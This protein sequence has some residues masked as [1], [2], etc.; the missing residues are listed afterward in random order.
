MTIGTPVALTNIQSSTDATSYASASV[1]PTGNG[2]VLVAFVQSERTTSDAE[3]PSSIVAWGLTW[4]NTPTAGTLSNAWTTGGATNRRM[5]GWW[6][7]C[8]NVPAAG[9][10]TANFTNTH[11]G[12]TVSVI[13]TSGVNPTAPIVQVVNAT[14][15]T[16]TQPVTLAAFASANNRALYAMAG[17]LAA[18][19]IT[20]SGTELFEG[21]HT[22]PTITM[23]TQYYAPNTTA[24]G[25]TWTGNMISAGM[26][27]EL[28]E[29]TPAA[30]PPRRLL[31]PPRH[32][33]AVR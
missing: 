26:G 13:E 30:K 33:S 16:T 12:C 23:E 31:L 29:Y 14:G 28:N 8:P 1:T 2:T 17:N 19:A 9:T 15:T 24:L 22:A 3:V 21:G 27:L 18:V 25:A 10:F 7:Y 6:A 5:T 11:I 20:P 32:R 4:S